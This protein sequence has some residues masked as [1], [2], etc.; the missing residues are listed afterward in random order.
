M[1]SPPGGRG[2]ETQRWASVESLM[3]NPTW[4]A[5]SRVDGVRR[6]H[7]P[8]LGRGARRRPASPATT[9]RSTAPITLAEVLRRAVAL[10]PG[11]RLAE[12]SRSARSLVGDRP[13]AAEDPDEV[14]VPPGATVEFLPPFAGG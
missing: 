3:S 14:V 4:R 9:C 13:V 5:R 2:T 8:L 12:C 7:R 1:G 6:R 11:T 10:H